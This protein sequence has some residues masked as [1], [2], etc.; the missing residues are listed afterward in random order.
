MNTLTALFQ[1][2]LHVGD[3]G[4]I[5]TLFPEFIAPLR[6]VS[7]KRFNSEISLSTRK[8]TVKSLICG[9]AIVV[10]IPTMEYLSLIQE[11]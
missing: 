8:L 10:R 3:N 9:N 1:L 5:I 6:A 7:I 2:A 4:H 11:S